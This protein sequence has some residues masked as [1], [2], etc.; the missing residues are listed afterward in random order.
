MFTPLTETFTRRNMHTVATRLFNAIEWAKAETLTPVKVEGE[1][2]E[3]G[4]KWVVIKADA[5]WQ[6]FAYTTSD[7]AAVCRV[8]VAF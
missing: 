8:A 2:E 6:G 4:V 5:Q 1:V 3:L 7:D